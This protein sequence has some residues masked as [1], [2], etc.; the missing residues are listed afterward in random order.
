MD[1]VKMIV[2]H[3]DPYVFKD[4]CRRDS[5]RRSR[6]ITTSFWILDELQ[7]IS[8]KDIDASLDD[9]EED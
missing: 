5:V 9:Y 4:E 7:G 6:A 3:I 8:R 1:V 2:Q